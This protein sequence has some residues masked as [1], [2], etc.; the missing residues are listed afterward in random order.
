MG[1]L[2]APTPGSIH[3][4]REFEPMQRRLS[5][6]AV[7]GSAAVILAGFVAGPG[8]PRSLAS[9]AVGSGRSE[10]TMLGF[11]VGEERRYIIGP[12]G[13]LRPGEAAAWSI[14]LDRIEG[15]APNRTAAFELTHESNRWGISHAGGNMVWWKHR[16]E[17]KLN[18][19]GFPV[20]LR[21]TVFEEHTGEAPWRGDIMASSYSFRDGQFHKTVELPGQQWEF[22]VPI[23]RHRDLDL[24]VPE[25][26][27]LFFPEAQDYDFF[28]NPALLEF[29]L[30]NPMPPSW[31]RETMYFMPTLPIRYP[32]R[33]WVNRERDRQAS[34][35]RYYMR[36]GVA[37]GPI[38]QLEV[39]GRTLN[40]RRL[41]VG[42]FI[43]DAYI[44]E[45]GKVVRVDID[46]DP[47]TR[48]DRYIRILYPSEY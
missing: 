12:P 24:D 41:D 10:D 13:A 40:V 19:Q 42:N 17:L 21:F 23:A 38:Q 39:G 44:D 47:T 43:R 36:I 32:D 15:E 20:D 31:K 16:G 7:W 5:V 37:A 28:S 30:P 26:L 29:S 27:Y 46:P 6:S 35:R 11:E 48:K 9:P 8:V 22:R 3:P 33:D 25:G 4:A 14:R 2:P 1:P 45:F 34:V 18:E